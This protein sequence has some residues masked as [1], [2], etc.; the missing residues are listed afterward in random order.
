MSAS[1]IVSASLIIA[2]NLE[3]STSRDSD[4]VAYFVVV[5]ACLY[6]G[7]WATTCG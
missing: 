3:E 5:F 1:H 4:V 7:G 2:F 6:L